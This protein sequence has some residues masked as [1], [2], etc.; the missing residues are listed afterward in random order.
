MPKLT[1]LI[2]VYNVECY[3]ENVVNSIL[4][5][6]FDDYELLL[7]ND[8]STDR[9]GAIC[10]ELAEK[11]DR[12]RVFHIANGG[13]SNARNFGLAKATGEYVHF[14][15][16]DDLLEKG[17]YIRFA[18]IVEKNQ[19]D[20]VMCGSLQ[21]NLGRNT[22]TVVAPQAEIYLNDRNH[23]IQY[24]DQIPSN[25]M[26]CLIHYIWNKWYKREFLLKN[27]LS[28][29]SKLS[30]GEDYVFNCMA[31][32]AVT[33]I[34][35]IPNTFYHYFLRGNSLVSA[36]QPEPWKSRQMLFD[37][38]KSLYEYYGIW[39]SNEETIMKEEGKM[40][41]VALRS[42]NSRH[43]KLNNA[44][45]N[46]FLKRMSTSKQMSLALYYLENSEKKIHKLWWLMIR[47]FGMFGIKIVLL[48][49]Y[50]NRAVEE[51]Q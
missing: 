46:K 39:Q 1:V 12:I 22:S 38:H 29:S 13:V 51:K 33:D 48:A 18:T 17:M 10:D 30:L 11:D 37:A 31:V 32:K 25:E 44:E 47:I 35:I 45:K 36:F 34:Y 2:P 43:C 40:C 42:V 26:K 6:E 21:I 9:S 5:Q 27:N 24:L 4:M 20:I 16:S 23:I 49:D 19:P 3:L 50:V 7:I 8:G 15:D 41:F 28:F 14:V